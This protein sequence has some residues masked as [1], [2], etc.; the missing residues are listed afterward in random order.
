MVR[1]KGDEDQDMM[2]ISLMKTEFSD[3]I[4]INK[5]SNKW[6]SAKETNFV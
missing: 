6:L 1:I 3:L 4:A 2:N 5:E